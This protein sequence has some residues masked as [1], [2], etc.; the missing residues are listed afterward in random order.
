MPGVTGEP[1]GVSAGL[2]VTEQAYEAVHGEGMRLR[3]LDIQGHD[4]CESFLGRFKRAPAA[5]TILLR[6]PQAT[7]PATCRL[8]SNPSALY[9]LGISFTNSLGGRGMPVYRR[10]KDSDTW[11][12]CTNCS[13]YPTKADT[14]KEQH[15]KPTTGE[16]CDQCRAKKKA[17]TCKT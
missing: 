17:G 14:E 4:R 6:P 10:R 9:C 15:T 13:Q 1:R 12:W 5:P 11:H 16:L 2:Q 7:A 3:W 8:T